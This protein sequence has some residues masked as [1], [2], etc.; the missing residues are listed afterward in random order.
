MRDSIFVSY[1]RRDRSSLDELRRHL[2][3]TSDAVRLILW[4]DT[5]ISP[6]TQWRSEI[7]ENLSTAAAAVLLLSPAFFASDFITNY[8]LPPLLEA[9]AR[10]ELRIFPVVLAACGHERVTATY[11]AVNDPARPLDGLDAGERR[12][13]WDR[14]AEGLRAVEAE[15]GDEARIA[16]ERTRLEHDVAVVPSVAAVTDK[17]RR[18][19]ADPAFEGHEAMRENTLT[20]LEGQ[21]CQAISGWLLEESKRD[22]QSAHRRQA[23]VGM[24][25]DIA[26]VNERALQRATELTQQFA[27][28]ALAMLKDA[29]HRPDHS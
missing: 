24:L 22:V 3:P 2:S 28:E 7:D 5:H 29:K 23:I 13:V 18:A 27:D 9:A 6:A 21:R 19:S 20:F 14:L 1:S 8:E 15:I 10:S 12:A 11:Q 16:A 25:K 4:D 26:E 17:I